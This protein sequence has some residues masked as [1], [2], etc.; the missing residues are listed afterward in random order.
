MDYQSVSRVALM[1]VRGKQVAN[2]SALILHGETSLEDEFGVS[3]ETR[4]VLDDDAIY[5][6]NDGQLWG[7]LW[8]NPEAVLPLED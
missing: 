4:V 1:E 8:S 6:A 7:G 2:Q 3:G 5:I